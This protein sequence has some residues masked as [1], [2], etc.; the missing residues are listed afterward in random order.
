MSPNIFEPTK[1]RNMWTMIIY[2]I[3][4][5]RLFTNKNFAKTFLN[6]STSQLYTYC[7][8]KFDNFKMVNNSS[9]TH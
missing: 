4:D 6:Y 3:F 8:E 9:R 1:L 7:S 2:Q 5:K